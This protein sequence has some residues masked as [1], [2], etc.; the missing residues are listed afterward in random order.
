MEARVVFLFCLL[1]TAARAASPSKSC[2]N[3][4]DP[5]SIRRA[6]LQDA[7]MKCCYT[8]DIEE[9]VI[10]AQTLIISPNNSL[11][12]GLNL[13]NKRFE[14]NQEKK[15][16]MHCSN[17]IIKNIALHDAGLYQCILTQS[18]NSF[19]TPGTF[20]QVYKPVQ[21]ILNINERTK[22]SIITAQGVLLLL[23]VLI[24]GTMLICKSKGLQEL[25]KK[26]S[27]EEE[28]IYEGLNLDD[29]NSTY[30]QIQRSLVQGPYQD[31]CN[32]DEDDIQLEKP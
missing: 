12:M 18:N 27:K 8:C 32:N 24:P 21:M 14:T 19:F 3:G 9:E 7:S 17:L 16:N 26:K 2:K 25:E 4:F 28:N 20:L 22:N 1:A 6:I 29:C 31:V 30:H 11:I 23:V 13:T 15:P 10:W 5:P